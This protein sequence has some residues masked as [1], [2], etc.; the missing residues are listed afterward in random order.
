M[1][2]LP[3]PRVHIPGRKLIAG[4]PLVALLI[5]GAADLASVALVKLS[6]PD[7]AGEAAR[8]GVTAIQYDRSATP[9]TAQEAYDAA[10]EVAQLHR[11]DIDEKSFVVH[12]DGSVEFTARRSSPT[13]LF[14]HLPGLRDLTETAV[15]VSATRADW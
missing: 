15:S 13:L 12:A 7:D 11:L 9:Q 3:R 8:A 2:T 1:P 14:Q 4:V 5:V 10:K 6:A